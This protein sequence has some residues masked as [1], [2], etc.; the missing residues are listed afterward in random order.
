VREFVC[1]RG[2]VRDLVCESIGV[3]ES[4]GVCE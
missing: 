3:C 1:E 2:C 4:V